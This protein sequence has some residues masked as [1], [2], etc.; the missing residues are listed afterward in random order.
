MGLLAAAILCPAVALIVGV[1]I[2]C[3]RLDAPWYLGMIWQW[4]KAKHRARTQLVRPEDLERVVFHAFVSYSQNDAE[5]VKCQLLPNLEG[6][7]GGL[8]ICRHERD[9]VPG[10]TI[11]ENIICCIERSRRCVFILS[12]HFVRSEWCHYEL[13]FASHQHLASGSQ[14]VILV[15]L[16]PLPQYLVPSKYNQLKAMM[17]RHTYLEWPQDRAKHR[18]FWANLRAALQADLPNAPIRDMEE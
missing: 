8:H 14:N 16:E 13:Y 6:S 7:G 4:A 3:H 17:N 11:V 9:F 15:L 1:V 5:W 10:K 2:L 12:A 18:L